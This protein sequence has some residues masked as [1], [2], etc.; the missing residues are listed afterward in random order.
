MVQHF[1]RPE[2]MPPANGYS[3][4]VA[5]VGR[6][7]AVSG[8]LPLDGEGALVSA[9]DSLA[10]ARQ[11]FSNLHVALRAAG[12]PPE[13]ILRLTFFLTDL[14][15]LDS[16]RAARDE[17]LGS[18]PLPASSLVQVVGLVVPDARVEI[19]ALAVTSA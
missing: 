15:D 13:H 5:G 17:V 16:V 11:V 1:E 2:G 12:A 7:I 9:T 8:Q 10:Q 14:A 18:G 3:H 4:I 6:L 19:D